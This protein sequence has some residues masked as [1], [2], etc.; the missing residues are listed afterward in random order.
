MQMSTAFQGNV[1]EQS[2]AYRKENSRETTLINLVEE[3]K[4][5]RDNRLTAAILWTDMSKV[6]DSLHPPL[7]LSKLK[8]YGK[9]LEQ[10]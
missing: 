7:L 9:N 1:Y 3:W 8:A 10:L 4:R 6:I 5:A 2:S